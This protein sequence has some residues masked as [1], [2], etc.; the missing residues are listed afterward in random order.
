MDAP[1]RQAQKK[2]DGTRGHRRAFADPRNRRPT[3]SRRAYRPLPSAHAAS[4]PGWPGQKVLWAT[5][6]SRNRS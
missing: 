3:R 2:P 5:L 1:Q 4:A 6:A